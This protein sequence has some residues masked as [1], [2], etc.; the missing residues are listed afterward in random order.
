MT[1]WNHEVVFAVDGP[2]GVDRACA[3]H[4]DI[5]LIDI[6]LPGFDGYEIARRIRREGSDWA[7][8]VRL[9]ALTGY[10]QAADRVR[11]MEAGFDMH[12]LKPVDPEKLQ[13]VL[14]G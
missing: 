5:A 12:L 13:Q 8:G 9:I 2:E 4:P 6:G 10:G 1:A 3:V 14:A 7:R 11:A